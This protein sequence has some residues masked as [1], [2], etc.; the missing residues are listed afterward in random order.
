MTLVLVG[1]P[2]PVDRQGN[3][4]EGMV[5]GNTDLTPGTPPPF[6][7]PHCWQCREMVDGFTLD[8]ASSTFWIGIQFV[9]HGRT[10][11]MKVSYKDV[12]KAGRRGGILWVFKETVT[13]HG[14]RIK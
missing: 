12:L 4:S 2:K 5:Y 13:P 6:L 7:V 10:G 1:A 8:Y 3:A 9:C 14:T 11:G